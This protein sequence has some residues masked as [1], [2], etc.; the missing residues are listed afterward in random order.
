MDREH[1]NLRA[2]L[3]W[4]GQTPDGAEIEL[5]LAT[6]LWRFWEVRCLH[7]EGSR[8]LAGALARSAGLAPE[9][10]AK[11]LTAAGN[12]ARDRAALEEATAYHEESLALYRLLDDRSGIASSLNNL[13]VIARD[14]GEAERTIRL[15][16]ESHDLFQSLGDRHG[17]AITLIGLGVA[18]GQQGNL[19]RA[20]AHYTESLALFRVSGDTWHTAWVLIYQAHLLVKF[21]QTTAA[22]RSAEEGLGILRTANDP[23]GVALALSALGRIAQADGD[24]ETAAAQFVEALGLLIE[25]GITRAVPGRLEDLAGVAL[26]GSQPDRAA[27]L[28]GAAEALRETAGLVG[29]AVDWTAGLIDLSELRTGLQA[30]AWAEGRVLPLKA[31]LDETNALA[32]EIARSSAG[33]PPASAVAVIEKSRSE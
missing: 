3:T 4:S 12:L 21:G 22:R 19:E 1:D 25:G 31:V 6:A 28:G 27:R 29:G 9:F 32:E 13:S 23:W 17:A 7:G 14:R 24:H 8:W 11:A 26:A 10:R 16:Q 18:A 33:Q 20:L 30:A 5:R 2:A 15:A